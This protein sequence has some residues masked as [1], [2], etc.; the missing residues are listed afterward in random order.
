MQNSERMIEQGEQFEEFLRAY[1]ECA[2]WSSDPDGDGMGASLLDLGYDIDD[3]SEKS[4][5][6]MFSDCIKFLNRTDTVDESPLYLSHPDRIID[7]GHDFWLNRN[8]NGA[9]FW[10]GDWPEPLATRLDE[11]SKSF[12]ECGLYLGDDDLIH[13]M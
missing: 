10:D 3:I 13:A 4:F 8:G 6:R 7:A 1:V 2:L 11:L 9:G 12:G 5:S